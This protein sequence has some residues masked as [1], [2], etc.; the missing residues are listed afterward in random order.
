VVLAIVFSRSFVD[1][2]GFVGSFSGSPPAGSA[3]G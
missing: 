3:A 1:F 2:V